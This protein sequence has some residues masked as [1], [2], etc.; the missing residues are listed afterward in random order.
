MAPK[1]F[2]GA[3]SILGSLLTRLQATPCWLAVAR[4][5]NLASCY[6]VN[7]DQSLYQGM[8]LCLVFLLH[9]IQVEKVEVTGNP[10]AES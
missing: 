8:M 9:N 1:P 4:I 3:V 5:L 10:S 6:R 2:E 7:S